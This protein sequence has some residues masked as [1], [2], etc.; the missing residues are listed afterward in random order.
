MCCGFST[1]SSEPGLRGGV[2]KIFVPHLTG[3]DELRHGELPLAVVVK[4]PR[5]TFSLLSELVCVSLKSYSLTIPNGNK[6]RCRP[7]ETISGL[8]FAREAC[9]LELVAEQGD[10]GDFAGL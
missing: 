9:S 3:L 2:C 7:Y 5:R 4:F 10:F 1:L 8:G 6:L